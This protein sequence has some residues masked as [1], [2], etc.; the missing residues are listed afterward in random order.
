M[1]DKLV[2]IAICDDDEY[3]CS[4]LERYILEYRDKY[5]LNADVKIF[6][7]GDELLKYTENEHKFDLIF[8]DIE[9]DTKTGIEIGNTIR[10]DMDDHISKIVFVTSKDGYEPQLFGIQPL[11]FIKKPVNKDKL[12]EVIDLVLK[13]LHI[14]KANFTYK[15]AHYFINVRIDEIIYFEKEGRKIKIVTTTGVDY[16]NGTLEQ[17]RLENPK[18]FAVPHNSFVVN[19]EKVDRYIKDQ[20][21]MKNGDKVPVS[22]RNA[23]EMRLKLMNFER[24]VGYDTL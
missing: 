6:Y 24:E 1:I 23:K 20:L 7:N 4:V 8:L 15:K 21:I 12:F 17:I 19:W 16:F 9:L 10:K 13:L 2:N 22:Q 18:I 14:E 11:E 3:F 5:L